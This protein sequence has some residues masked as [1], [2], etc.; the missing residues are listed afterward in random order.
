MQV[1]IIA[2]TGFIFIMVFANSLGMLV[3]GQVLCG[4]PWGV[5]QTLTTAYASEVSR[6]K[7]DHDGYQ[8]DTQVCPIQLRGYLA[9][10]V[11]LCWGVGILLSSGVVTACLPIAS[12]W[13]WRI[14]FIVQW[15]WIPPLFAIVWF[16]PPSPWW[17]VRKGRL[18]E[19][20]QAV[21]R[22]T[23]PNIIS[24]TEC[25]N[26]VAMMQ[27]TT[28]MEIQAAFGTSYIDCFR[29]ID[30][31]RTEIVMMTF[32]MQL[33]SGQNLI[34]QG[35]QFLQTAGISTDLSFSL[36][37]VLNSMFII[38]TICS[39]GRKSLLSSRPLSCTD[40]IVL[41]LFGRR[42][43]YMGGMAC[44]CLVLFIIGALGFHVN[45]SVNFGMGGLLIGLNFIYNCS[46]GPVCYTIIAEMSS[47]RLRQK[48][49]VLARIAY[50]IMNIICGIIV[51]RMLSPLA[52]LVQTYAL[53]SPPIPSS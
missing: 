29:G 25:A 40:R 19:A 9:A 7:R 4:I 23:N 48:S 28:E 44:M 16:C 2:L 26:T 43:I 18:E 1:S 21:R 14:P 17:L 15:V 13:S 12:D 3:A 20:Q 32:A 42:T 10:Y 37:M 30:R 50:Q 35:I 41:R 52:W 39:W 36:N 33:L 47:T 5:F 6:L 53:L 45:Q 51:P 34:G 27:H 22:L 49:I 46:L 24:E 38:G 31:R 11:N 8:A